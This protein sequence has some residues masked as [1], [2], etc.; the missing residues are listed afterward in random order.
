MENAIEFVMRF[1][2]VTR[3]DVLKLY[4]DE[5]HAYMR[6]TSKLDLE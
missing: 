5:V 2:N 3:E 4:M 1:Y 6:L